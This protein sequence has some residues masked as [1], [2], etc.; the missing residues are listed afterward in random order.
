MGSY[1]QAIG[2]LILCAVLFGCKQ[3]T[4]PKFE[5]TIDMTDRKIYPHHDSTSTGPIWDHIR[6]CYRYA[7]DTEGFYGVPACISLAQAILES[8]GGTSA[9]GEYHNYFGHRSFPL[10][11]AHY[12]QGKRIQTESG[13]WRAYETAEEAYEE[14]G[15]FF[16]HTRQWDAE[17][18]KFKYPYSHLIRRPYEYWLDNLNGYG[19]DAFYGQ[20]LKQII[21][22]Y[23]LTEYNLNLHHG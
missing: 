21:E 13:L 6:T 5:N 2:F 18:K 3:E 15:R 8:G 4:E 7:Q 17:K 11:E 20:R 23:R 10:D 19:G 12:Y 9:L 14:H 16:I 22:R 1:K